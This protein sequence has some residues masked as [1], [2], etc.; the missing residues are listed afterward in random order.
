VIPTGTAA[1]RRAAFEFAAPGAAP[2]EVELAVPASLGA[3]TRLV[4]VMHG[5]S[6][7]AAAYRDA[8]LAWAGAADHL[9]ACPRFDPRGWRGTRAYAL[10]GVFA[11]RDG[12][13][14]RRPEAAWSFT[15]VAA[16]AGHLRERYA[17]EDPGFDLW[18]HSAG[19]QFVH[20][21][22]LLR[23]EAPVRRLLAANAGWYTLPD[24]GVAFPYGLR[25][26]ALAFSPEDVRRWLAAPLVL[27]RGAEDR[28][29]DEHLRTTLEAE[30]QGRTR[31]ARAAHVLERA[32]ALD[33]ATGW[34][35]ADVPGAGHD[36]LP[37]ARAA[38]RRW[39]QLAP[40]AA[41]GPAAPA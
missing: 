6:R 19:A 10:G 13:G 14:E 33:P 28:G 2:V 29:R 12:A 21:F 4:V 16:L 41:A 23:P 34:R 40:R 26:P 5:M 3:G 31:H 38:Q 35:I 36:F 18:G 24:L 1:A 32:R 9:V 39:A 11:G 25:H 27:M 15:V 37:M 17:L 30:R 7:N 8:W 20:R 22:P